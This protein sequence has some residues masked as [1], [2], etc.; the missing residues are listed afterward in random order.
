MERP[1]WEEYF[2]DF[3]YLAA[4]R[5]TCLRRAVG[6]VIV[7]DRKIMATGYNGAP[8]KIKHCREA[9]CLRNK[10]KVPSG[11]RHELC[12]G[13]HAEQNAIIQAAY[14][15]ANVNGA[16]FYCT[17]RPCIICIKMI[18]NAGIE[19]IFYHQ[20]YAE[21]DSTTRLADQMTKAAGIKLIKVKMNK[22]RSF[23]KGGIIG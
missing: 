4:K 3:A 14:H 21:K 20:D 6:A 12:R 18:I 19:R 11:K 1:S 8:S 5:T 22:D 13:L 15:G 7:K 17:N 23:A 2:M 9:G 16:D 10:L